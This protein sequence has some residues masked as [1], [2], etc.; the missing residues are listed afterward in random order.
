MV[1]PPLDLEWI[2]LQLKSPMVQFCTKA[3]L[4]T[5]VPIQLILLF[6]SFSLSRKSSYTVVK[7]E[8]NKIILV[9]PM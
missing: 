7:C 6:L 1:L 9:I 5:Q 2:V 4:T 3:T 8:A